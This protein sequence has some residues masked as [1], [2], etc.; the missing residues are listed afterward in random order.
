MK[1]AFNTSKLAMAKELIKLI[2]ILCFVEKVSFR[3][4]YFT[5]ASPVLECGKI[6]TDESLTNLRVIG[7]M[8][9][10]RG[11]SPWSALLGYVV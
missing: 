2:V 6:K 10:A 7:G 4:I 5:T 3:Q 11:N 1:T 9:I 8:E